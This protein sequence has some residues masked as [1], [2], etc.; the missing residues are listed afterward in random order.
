[1]NI[2]LEWQIGFVPG[3]LETVECGARRSQSS[4]PM[5][6]SPS[7]SQKPQSRRR[8]HRSPGADFHEKGLERAKGFEPSTPTL[9]RLCSTPELRPRRVQGAV[10]SRVLRALQPSAIIQSPQTLSA[11]SNRGAPPDGPPVHCRH[12]VPAGAF[13]VPEPAGDALEIAGAVCHGDKK[14]LGGMP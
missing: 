4:S 8:S 13:A 1:M 3:R 9:A 10:D 2:S 11:G 5:L 7:A 6:N 14:D 12:F